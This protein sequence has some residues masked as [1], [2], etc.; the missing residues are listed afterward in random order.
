MEEHDKIYLYP[1]PDIDEKIL[2]C[3]VAGIPFVACG[4]FDIYNT[5]SG[6]GL[7]FDYGFDLSW[8]QEASNAIRFQKICE[9][10]DVLDDISIDEIVSMTKK[11][12]AHNKEFIYKK[13]FF[14]NCETQRKLAIEKIFSSIE[15][16]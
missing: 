1:G 10:I 14:S 6:L 3:L 16:R 2:K 13:G 8:D 7:E 5:L 12:T 9:L 11:S 15:T 4:Q